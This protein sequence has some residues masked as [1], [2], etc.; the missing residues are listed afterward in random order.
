MSYR[1]L[2]IVVVNP[3]MLPLYEMSGIINSGFNTP[4]TS[5]SSDSGFLLISGNIFNSGVTL[6]IPTTGQDNI[7]IY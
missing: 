2:G 6:A 5:Y 4:T 1:K 3:E 7:L